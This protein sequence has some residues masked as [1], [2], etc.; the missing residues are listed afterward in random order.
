M[1][2]IF[3]SLFAIVICAILSLSVLACNPNDPS[4]EDPQPKPEPIVAVDGVNVQNVIDAFG[5][6]NQSEYLTVNV[7]FGMESGEEIVYGDCESDAYS[8]LTLLSAEIKIK[9][10]NRGYDFIATVVDASMD[11][12]DLINNDRCVVLYY[13]DGQ[14]VVAYK[15]ADEVISVESDET[16]KTF[17]AMINQLNKEIAQNP[18]MRKIYEKVLVMSEEI[19]SLFSQGV[20][21]NL[22]ETLDIDLK[23]T[24]NNALAYLKANNEKTLY[25]IVV[26]AFDITQTEEEI[27]EIILSTVEEFCADNPTLIELIDRIVEVINQDLGTDEQIDLREICNFI[28][29]SGLST[30]VF[31]ELVNYLAGDEILIIPQVSVSLYD[32]LTSLIDGIRVND[33]AQMILGT[34]GNT[35]TELVAYILETAKQTTVGDVV[36]SIIG[37]D[38][39]TLAITFEDL[40]TN[41]TLKTDSSSRLTNFSAEYNVTY[42]LLDEYEG[43]LGI[44]PAI[45]GDY[46]L[47]AS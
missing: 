35:V 5:P 24:V 27:E 29:E 45:C 30:T 1:R 26:T 7:E 42:T 21:A 39:S 28:E 19:K 32:Y 25:E 31:C 34:N 6:I 15:V 3:S 41:A 40:Y 38:F 4:K 14:M 8:E 16:S 10:T 18:E 20:F 9:K 46:R 11:T 17:N 37:M 47:A 44:I 36:Y 22:N 33:V 23:E 12:Y 13:V 43:S 2:K